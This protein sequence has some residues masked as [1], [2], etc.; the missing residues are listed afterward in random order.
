M[1][2]E[3]VNG[4]GNGGVPVLEVVDVAKSFGAVRALKGV[5][6]A[7]GQGEVLGLVGDNGAGKST[8]VNILSGS[9]RPDGGRIL[10]DGVDRTFE[11]PADARAHGIETVFQFLS[12]VPTLDIAENI[13][14]N[15]EIYGPGPLLR[16]FR[17]MDKQEMR[18]QVSQG[19]ERL[20]LTLPT[21]RTKVAALSGGQR[22]AVAI[23]R[24]VL[25]GSH[26]VLMD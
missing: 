22:Q 10:V 23:A 7:L 21:P 20:G 2:P 11:G 5:S 3:A 14:L 13:F 16:R 26:I 9:L 6:F 4:N 1:V 8:L 15:R 25:W 18:R 12:L 17:R 19:F 24:V